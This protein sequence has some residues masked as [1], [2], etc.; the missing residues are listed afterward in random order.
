MR[1]GRS[2]RRPGARASARRP[3]HSGT[4]RNP[5][6]EAPHTL[7]SRSTDSR[8]SRHRRSPSP[9]R[10]PTP[11]SRATPALE[12]TSAP[13]CAPHKPRSGSRCNLRA[14]R[15]R[16]LGSRTARA[17]AAARA[18]RAMRCCCSLRSG[19]REVLWPTH[20]ATCPRRGR[21]RGR[22]GCHGYDSR[23]RWLRR[24]WTCWPPMIRRRRPPSR[25][26]SARSALC[27][28][29]ASR[30]SRQRADCGCEE[31]CYALT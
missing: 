25:P 28:R 11:C 1:G 21:W 7:R 27:N 8:R 3:L 31:P 9:P 26:R 13:R 5:S 20:S 24:L 4:A 14:P 12:A 16:Q 29:L 23:R 19:P 18:R 17:R 10:A 2:L 30:H 6:P 22:R 15:C